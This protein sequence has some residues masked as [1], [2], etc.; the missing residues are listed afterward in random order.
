MKFCVHLSA[1]GTTPCK[2]KELP[3]LT[4]HDADIGRH[5][6]GPSTPSSRLLPSSWVDLDTVVPSPSQTDRCV[7]EETTAVHRQSAGRDLR[8]PRLTAVAEA[9]RDTADKF[10]ELDEETMSPLSWRSQLDTVTV[11]SNSTDKLMTPPAGPVSP[12]THTLD[13]LMLFQFTFLFFF[14]VVD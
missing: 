10:D 11:Y 5:S 14:R 3:W 13:G 12:H 9:G 6:D 8:R 4:C 1:N 7:A 2:N